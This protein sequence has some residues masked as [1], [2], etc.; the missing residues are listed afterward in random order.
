MKVEKRQAQSLRNSFLRG[1]F[2][3]SEFS[4]EKNRLALPDQ[5]KL[6]TFLSCQKSNFVLEND[7]KIMP[8]TSVFA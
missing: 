2:W 6:P 8:V 4:K 1:N 7:F 5:V 3:T